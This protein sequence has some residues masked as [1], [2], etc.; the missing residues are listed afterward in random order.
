MVDL[1]FTLFPYKSAG[2]LNIYTTNLVYFHE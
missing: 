2:I 1:G